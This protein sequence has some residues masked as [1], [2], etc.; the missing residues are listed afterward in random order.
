M[1]TPEGLAKLKEFAD[2]IA[3]HKDNVLAQP[4]IVTEAH[5]LGMSV[6]VWTCRAKDPGKF[7]NVR[8]EMNHLLRN[9]KVDAI[10]TDNPDQFPR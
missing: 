5:K 10:F 2:G 9:L 4:E 8:E 3:P 1:G 7:E 6:T